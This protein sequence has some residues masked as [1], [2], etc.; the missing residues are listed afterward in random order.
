LARSEWLVDGWEQICVLWAWA[1]TTAARRAA[2]VELS[3]MVPI[4][5]KEVTT[6]MSQKV[7]TEMLRKVPKIVR[8]NIDWQTGMYFE[9]VRRNEHL[10]ALAA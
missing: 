5:P 9:R 8:A 6:W 10:R 7:D 4:L 1:T 3:S 2:L